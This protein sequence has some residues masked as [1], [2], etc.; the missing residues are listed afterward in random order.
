MTRDDVHRPSVM[1]PA[2]YVLVGECDVH[3]EDGYF[4]FDWERYAELTGQPELAGNDY[5]ESDPIEWD[6]LTGRGAC[7]HCGNRRIRYW[8]FFLH[9]PTGKVVAVGQRCASTLSL[10]SREDIAR[11][12]QIE[13]RRLDEK[14]SGWRAADE[15][16]ERAYCDLLASEDAKGGSG[17]AGNEFV[18]SLLKYA[19]R[20]GEL[21]EGQRD[22]VLEGIE[23]RAS[24][25]RERAERDALMNDPEPA[26]VVEGRIEVTGRLLTIKS[27]RSNYGYDRYETKMLV[28]DDRGFKVWG[29]FPE[30]LT[31]PIFEL[32]KDAG[33]S[34]C[35]S[36]IRAGAK[37]RVSF[38][39]A[40]EKSRKDETFGFFKR[41]TKAKVIA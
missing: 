33:E 40:V 8:L 16:N 30:S 35:A 22:A 10:A 6:E 1:N 15:R 18:D 28:L 4:D 11:R 38:T 17:A 39:A 19:R 36:L 23:K 21:T 24:R 27:Q 3:H 32:A 2:D 7:C 31:D 37:V 29:T 41:P 5:R 26:A 25:E 13:R 20:H 12:E 14:L 34:D 9:E